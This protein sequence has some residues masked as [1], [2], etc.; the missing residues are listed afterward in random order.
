MHNIDKIHDLLGQIESLV[1]EVRSSISEEEG[2]EREDIED[3]EDTDEVE[4]EVEVEESP[5]GNGDKM[6]LALSAL[7]SKMGA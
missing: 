6:Q 7:K 1:A 4:E 5:A 3:V 2:E